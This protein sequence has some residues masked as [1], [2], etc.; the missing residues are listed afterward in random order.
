MPTVHLLIKG[1]VQGV[2][3]RASAKENA[4]ALRL[5]GWINNTAEGDVEAIAT[6][7]EENIK[8]FIEWCKKGPAKAVVVSVAVTSMP[9]QFFDSFSVR[10]T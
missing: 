2:F 5:T 3:Y 9:H 10:R 6:G 8:T 4:T 1:R 7:T